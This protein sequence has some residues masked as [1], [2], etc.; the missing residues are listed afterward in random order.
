MDMGM[1]MQPGG[2]RRTGVIPAANIYARAMRKDFDRRLEQKRIV[3]EAMQ[4]YFGQAT[5]TA[6]S[7]PVK[8]RDVDAGRTSYTCNASPTQSSERRRR[9]VSPA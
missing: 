1:D 8:L 6:P 5:I 7:I 4:S 3:A 2:G 9:G